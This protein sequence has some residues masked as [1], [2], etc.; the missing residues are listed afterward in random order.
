MDLRQFLRIMF[1]HLST[2][3]RMKMGTELVQRMMKEK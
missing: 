1:P 2:D 3:E